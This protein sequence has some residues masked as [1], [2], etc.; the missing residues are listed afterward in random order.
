LATQYLSTLSADRAATLLLALDDGGDLMHFLAPALMLLVV[1]SAPRA[2]AM[3]LAEA[4]ADAFFRTPYE[5][6]WKKT[7][8]RGSLVLTN[9]DD[10]GGGVWFIDQDADGR[11]IFHV[12]QLGFRAGEKEFQWSQSVVINARAVERARLEVS[13]AEVTLRAR[14]PRLICWRYLAPDRPAS[15]S[16]IRDRCDDEHVSAVK[17]E[18]QKR[19]ESAVS[20]LREACGWR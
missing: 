14:R 7:V 10:R 8:R 11:C 20:A 5:A 4:A 13:A 16:S 12:L 19:F 15:S 9:E 1:L 6:D 2:F 17:I 3:E 18:H